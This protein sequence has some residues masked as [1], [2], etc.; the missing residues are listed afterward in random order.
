ME[1][2]LRTTAEAPEVTALGDPA[3]QALQTVAD[4]TAEQPKKGT[5]LRV[6]KA[7]APALRLLSRADGYVAAH[8]W[9]GI[10]LCLAVMVFVTAVKF[11]VFDPAQFYDANAVLAAIASGGTG[12]DQS[13]ALIIGFFRMLSVPFGVLPLSAWAWLLLLPGAA[14]FVAVV[15]KAPPESLAALL[16]LVGFS[17]LLPFYVFTVGKDFL[18]YLLFFL[19]ALALLYLPREPLKLLGGLAVV[20]VTAAFFRS[21]YVLMFGFAMGLYG[22]ALLYRRRRTISQRAIF[23]LVLACVVVLALFALRAV[24]PEAAD[25]LFTVRTVTNMG[26]GVSYGSDKVIM[27]PLPLDRSVPGFLGNYISA[28]IRM[29]FPA[30]LCASAGDIPFAVFQTLLTVLLFSAFLKSRKVSARTSVYS[31]IIAFLLMSFVFEPD[32]GSWFRHESAAFPL[33]W[34]GIGFDQ[35]TSRGKSHGISA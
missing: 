33:L 29:M 5:L 30:E 3:E 20:L 25:R 12:I 22:V 10:L 27:D 18:Q 21:Y 6:R 15:R 13:F 11:R 9:Q 34:L 31:L 17:V 24:L 19:M 8:P 4:T 2:N 32:F 23:L 14:V 7:F 1:H 35:K 28:A 26:I 16:L